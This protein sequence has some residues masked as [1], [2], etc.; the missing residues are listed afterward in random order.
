MLW[1]LNRAERLPCCNKAEWKLCFH[2][3]IYLLSQH[4]LKREKTRSTFSACRPCIVCS[5]IRW[6]RDLACLLIAEC[7]W[8]LGLFSTIPEDAKVEIRPSTNCCWWPVGWLESW[9]ATGWWQHQLEINTGSALGAN[10]RPTTNQT[11]G[12]ESG[13]LHQ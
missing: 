2:L 10:V 6:F 1:G 7:S 12:R 4:N 11:F 9:R 8:K 13:K 5:R 3:H